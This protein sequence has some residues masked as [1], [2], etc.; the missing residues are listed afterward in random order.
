MSSLYIPDTSPLSDMF[1]KYFLQGSD[2]PF[3]LLSV[4]QGANI[5]SSDEV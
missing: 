3:H 2:L 4:F 5:Q 1:W